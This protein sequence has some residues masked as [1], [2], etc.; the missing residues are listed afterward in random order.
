MGYNRGAMD[1]N[2]D[3]GDR[4]PKFA[5]GDQRQSHTLMLHD[6]TKV[7]MW[8]TKDQVLGAQGFVSVGSRRYA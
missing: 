6:D 2:Y 5:E 1:H 7:G 3:L 8:L 4:T